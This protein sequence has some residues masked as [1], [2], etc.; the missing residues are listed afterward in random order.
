LLWQGTEVIV[1]GNDRPILS[2]ERALHI[3]KHAIVRQKKNLDMSSRWEPDTKTDWPTGRKLTSTS[4]EISEITTTWKPELSTEMS[5]AWPVSKPIPTL[6][7]GVKIEGP[8]PPAF[9]SLKFEPI[10]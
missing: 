6:G 8:G 5:N 4:S 10:L 2:S 7:E 3:K 9:G 1:R